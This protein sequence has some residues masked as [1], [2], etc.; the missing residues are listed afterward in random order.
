MQGWLVGRVCSS[1]M[2]Q[3]WGWA[4]AEDLSFSSP[5]EE[6]DLPEFEDLKRDFA[7]TLVGPP[8]GLPLDRGQEFELHINTG[9]AP[10]AR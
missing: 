4:P 10:M 8:P 6:A 3:K 2:A 7:V 5:V 9:Y 1:M